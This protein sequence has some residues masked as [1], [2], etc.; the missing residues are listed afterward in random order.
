[1]DLSKV[2]WIVIIAVVV[3]A[4]FLASGPGVNAMY[5]RATKAV[6]GQDPTRDAAD[7]ATLSK[8][9]GYLTTLLQYEKAEKFY[10]ASIDRYGPDGKNFWWNIYKRARCY[11][12]MRKYEDAVGDLYFLWREDGDSY[13]E[14]VPENYILKNRIAKLIEVHQF[15]SN[16]Y[17]GIIE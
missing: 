11:E 12:K 5:N 14:R 6:V 9:G 16:M 2:K 8:Y 10:S 4:I 3:G 15:D 17:P 7:E 13:D 1:M